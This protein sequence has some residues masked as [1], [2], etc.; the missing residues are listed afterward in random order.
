VTPRRPR[1]RCSGPLPAGYSH[2]DRQCY[3]KKYCRGESCTNAELD[4]QREQYRKRRGELL[5]PQNALKGIELASRSRSC[6]ACD[7]LPGEYCRRKNGMRATR[8][9]H[10]RHPKG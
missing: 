6:P 9:H 10:A 8:S 5:K 4:Y 1:P 7:A 3:I 2:G